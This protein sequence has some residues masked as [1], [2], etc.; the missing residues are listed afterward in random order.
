MIIQIQ[1]IQIWL[2]A[3]YESRAKKQKILLYP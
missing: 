3:R 1:I 2:H